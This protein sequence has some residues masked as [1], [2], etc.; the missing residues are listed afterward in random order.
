MPA[1]HDRVAVEQLD[2]ERLVLVGDLRGA[3]GEEARRGDVGGQ[4]LQVA[5]GVGG[6]GHDARA[7]DLVA[8]D[9]LAGELERLDPPPSSSLP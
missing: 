8:A 4:V 7:L 3:L 6:L 9:R 2:L 5:G 1:R